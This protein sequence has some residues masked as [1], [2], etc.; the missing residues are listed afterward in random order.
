MKTKKRSVNISHR[1]TTYQQRA[2]L[3]LGWLDGVKICMQLFVYDI[4]PFCYYLFCFTHSPPPPHPLVIY[5]SCLYT[6]IV[7]LF[8]VLF[9]YFFLFHVFLPFAP[10]NWLC[11][12]LTATSDHNINMLTLNSVPVV[13]LFIPC[14]FVYIWWWWWWGPLP[15]RCTYL[16]PQQ[17]PLPLP[18]VLVDDIRISMAVQT[19]NNRCLWHGL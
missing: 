10:H 13:L 17:L 18:P 14:I 6:Y 16:T 4:D 15:P 8:N 7:Y 2:S 5:V 3:G 9:Y 12:C 19:T 1:P 11:D